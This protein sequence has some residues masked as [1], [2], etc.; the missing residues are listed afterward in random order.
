[1][2]K[3]FNDFFVNIGNKVEEKIPHSDVHFSHFL[4]K[5]TDS[6]FF[7]QPVDEEEISN[8]ISQLNTSK[9]CGP[10]SV[11]TKLLKDNSELFS[12]PLKHIINLSFEEGCFPDMLKVANVCPIYKKKCKNKCENYRPISLLPNLSKL[13]ERAMH[14]RLYDFLEKSHILYDLQFGF[15]KKIQQLMTFLIS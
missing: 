14:S 8:M 4:S 3:S 13:F 12:S 15:R 7:I 1:M 5:D 9:S 2:A 10:N 6:I 11:P